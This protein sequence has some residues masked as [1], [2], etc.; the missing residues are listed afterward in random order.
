M[1][2]GP[3]TSAMAGASGSDQVALPFALRALSQM[4][5]DG[6]TRH[7]VQLVPLDTEPSA[8][9]FDEFA[10]G[11]QDLWFSLEDLWS[12]LVMVGRL[13]AEVDGVDRRFVVIGLRASQVGV[14]GSLRSRLVNL[15]TYRWRFNSEEGS[16]V[17]LIEYRGD[18]LVC[19]LTRRR[20]IERWPEG[21]EV[22]WQVDAFVQRVL[23]AASLVLQ[24]A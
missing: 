9:R 5:S 4:P 12:R 2:H 18:D 22:S 10:V 3:T 17:S 8:G 23:R 7:R 1:P 16:F 13:A 14:V 15:D 24:R 6:H 20:R 21:H 19:T 11:P